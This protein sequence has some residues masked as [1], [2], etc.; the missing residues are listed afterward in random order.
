M[1]VSG[2]ITVGYGVSGSAS[3]SKSKVNADYASVNKQSGIFAGDDGY[4]INIRNHTDLKGGIITSTQKAEDNAKNAFSTGSLKFADIENHATYSGEGFGIGIQGTVAGN[5][6]NQNSH[7]INV[8]DR[9]SLSH[10][11]IGYGHDSDKQHS[12]TKS[13]INTANITIRD[14][15][16]QKA[17]TG[18]TVEETIQAVK[19]DITLENHQNLSGRLDNNFDANRVQNE[20]DLQVE[21][22]KEFSPVLAQ[23]IA[24]TSDYLGNV[25]EYQQVQLLKDTLQQE[26]AH[27]QDAERLTELNIALNQVD[28]YL[29]DNQTQYKLFKEGGLGRAGLHAVGGG[30]LTGDVS[31][32]AGAGVTSLSAPIISQVAD[33]SGSLKPVVD[34]VGGLAI[35]YATGGTAGAFTGA[36]ADWNNRQLH[37]REIK[38]IKDIAKKYAKEQG[39]SVEQAEND[40]MVQAMRDIDKQYA[41]T[42]AGYNPQAEAFLR[43]NAGTFVDENGDTMLM[44]ANMGYYKDSTKYADQTGYT[45]ERQRLAGLNNQYNQKDRSNDIK[46]KTNDAIVGGSIKGVKNVPS[47]LINGGAAFLNNLFHTDAVPSVQPAAQYENE[48]EAFVGN[49]VGENIVNAVAIGTVGLGSYAQESRATAALNRE[50]QAARN[51]ARVENYFNAENSNMYDHF[52]TADLSN[53]QYPANDGF[54]NGYTATTQKVGTVLDRYGHIG[55]EYMSPYG[56][57]L[58]SRALPPGSAAKSYQDYHKYVVIKEFPSIEGEIA[59]AFGQKGGGIQVKPNFGERVKIKYLLDNHYLKEIK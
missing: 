2:S 12:I 7:L 23:G 24:W 20:I 51:A 59:P 39:I 57:S 40:L 52:K 16:K 9:N 50:T 34:T 32:A 41:D 45:A 49:Q 4:Q 8:A 28:N 25:S 46:Y 35:G 27:T 43:K 11:G 21:V 42:H 55:G 26:I 13:G 22:T 5:G 36:N 17:L 19:T 18:K 44:F 15:A 6:N 56:T 47:D 58:E 3:Y 14:T 48:A 10:D 1:N 53:W 54:L 31:G 37:N 30:I 33:N 29:T 38:K